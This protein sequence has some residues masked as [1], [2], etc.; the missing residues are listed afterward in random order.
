MA[1]LGSCSYTIDSKNRVF[2]PVKY[3]EELGETFY[4]T[5]SVEDCLTIYTEDEWNQFLIRLDKIP[6]SKGG[7]A[8]EYFMSVAV[9][10]T[11][12]ASGRILLEDPLRKHAALQ[13]NVIFVGAG[14]VVNIWSEENWTKR[15][16]SRDRVRLSAVLAEYEL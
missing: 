15:E 3:R 9:K 1:F 2:I 6:N 10:Y 4:I 12:D 8:K 11:P 13:K 7:D 14:R 5:R 16:A